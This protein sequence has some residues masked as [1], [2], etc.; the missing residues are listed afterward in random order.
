MP[1]DDRTT[2]RED[3]RALPEEESAMRSGS[4]DGPIKP[5]TA[6]SGAM[7]GKGGNHPVDDADVLLSD[8]EW[9]ALAAREDLSDGSD[10]E[11]EREAVLALD[12]DELPL[13]GAEWAALA[14]RYAAPFRAALVETGTPEAFFD[15]G[16]EVD[17]DERLVDDFALHA[18]QAR[19][20]G[21]VGTDEE[22]RRTS[23]LSP[24]SAK[25]AGP[26]L[27]ETATRR[28]GAAIA[29]AAF[30]IFRNSSLPGT[31]IRCLGSKG[32]KPSGYWTEVWDEEQALA[33]TVLRMTRGDLL[34]E[35]YSMLMGALAEGVTQAEFAAALT[36]GLAER[37]WAP[38]P[39]GGG[40]PARLARIHDSHLRVARAAG[41]WERIRRNQSEMPYL[42]YQVGPSPA[43]WEPHRHWEGLILPVDDEFWEYASPPNGFGCKCRV[44]QLTAAEADR[45]EHGGT[46]GKNRQTVEGKEAGAASEERTIRVSR[47]RPPRRVV[48]WTIPSTGVRT[49]VTIGID[50]GWDHHPGRERPH[51]V[52]YAWS[53]HVSRLVDAVCPETT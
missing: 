34:A 11:Q 24:G 8:A 36:A 22:R 51:G 48:D 35:I 53:Q 9:E 18:F 4:C 17:F 45:L 40:V 39:D 29:W 23:F 30:K 44:L 12:L 28:L 19:V 49:Q 32:L 15:R 38:P 20:E 6:E 3:D 26:S 16:I 37:G 7:D 46:A 21:A 43:R 1:D 25:P 31:A 41:Q 13:S 50:P 27:P 42:L 33:D 52:R 2:G 10:W 5:R 14:A 47:E